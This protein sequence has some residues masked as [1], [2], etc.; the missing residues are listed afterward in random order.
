MLNVKFSCEIKKDIF[1]KAEESVSDYIPG[2]AAWRQRWQRWVCFIGWG[3]ALA[4]NEV[5][6][7]HIDRTSMSLEA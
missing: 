6:Q 5:F 7:E 1:G 2:M 3:P 4:Q